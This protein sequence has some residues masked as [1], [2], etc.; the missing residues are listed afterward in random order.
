MIYKDKTE[1][2]GGVLELAE[3]R[4]RFAAYADE[5][6]DGLDAQIAALHRNG[7]DLLEV[8]SISGRNFSTYSADETRELRSRLE[9]EGIRIESIGSPFGKIG[10]TDEFAPHLENFRRTLDNA[11]I[12]GARCIRLFSFFMPGGGAA[13]LPQSERFLAYEPE[14]LSRLSQFLDA[15]RGS[16]VILC[17]ENEKGIYGDIAARCLRI[18]KALPDLR[19]VFDPANFIQTGQDTLEAWD[20]LSPYVEYMHIKDARPDGKVVPAGAGIGNLPAILRQYR[21][22]LLTLEP[23]LAVFS[24]LKTLEPDG[25]AASVDGTCYA[26][27]DEAFDAAASAM[28]KLACSS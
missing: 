15:A 9:N 17:H 18:H 13:Q 2:K 7:I 8:R 24:A 26:T 4:F 28:K 21:G 27:R 6:G 14:V 12:L 20:V 23:H 22:S 16:G 10:I 3:T 25:G 1:N 19:A 11:L 5:A